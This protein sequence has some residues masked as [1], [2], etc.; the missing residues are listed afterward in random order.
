MGTHL[1]DGWNKTV[2]MVLCRLNE[3]ADGESRGFLHAAEDDDI[4]FFVV[5]KG[6]VV[7][8]YFNDCPHIGT[9]LNWKNKNFLTLDKSLIVC[10][11]HGAVFRIEDGNCSAGPCVGQRLTPIDV[12]CKNGNILLHSLGN[13][14]L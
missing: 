10:A 8:G 4:E 14:T 3:I 7:F 5:R 11:T 13:I 12:T 2:T 6:E 9:P 1:R